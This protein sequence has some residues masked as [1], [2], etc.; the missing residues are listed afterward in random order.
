MEAGATCRQLAPPSEVTTT[1]PPL[2]VAQATSPS[3]AHR[4]R[5]LDPVPVERGARVDM[6]C[7]PVP[8]HAVAASERRRTAVLMGR[9]YPAQADAGGC[10]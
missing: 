10:W 9:C 7:G 1:V 3:T 6:E 8:L 5:R 2:P 4:P